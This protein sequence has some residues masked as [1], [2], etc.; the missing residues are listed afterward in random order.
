MIFGDDNQG[1]I[2][3]IHHYINFM[4][5]IKKFKVDIHLGREFEEENDSSAYLA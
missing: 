3:V 4:P 5:L 2:S 1:E